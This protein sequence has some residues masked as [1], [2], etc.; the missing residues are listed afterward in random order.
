MVEGGIGVRAGAEAR[1][2]T[3][4]RWRSRTRDPREDRAVGWGRSPSLLLLWETASV[5]DV[6]P[7]PL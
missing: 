1:T 4:W 3:D 5:L 6:R 2:G 7:E